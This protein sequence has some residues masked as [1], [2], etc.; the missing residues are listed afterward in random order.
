MKQPDPAPLPSVLR[1]GFM[2][3]LAVGSFALAFWLTTLSNVEPT[4]ANRR[5]FLP[6]VENRSRPSGAAPAGMV[7]VPGGEFSMGCDDPRPS[8]C[9]GP[10]AMADAR[11]V[12]RVYVDGF[13][14]DRTEVTN[15][16]FE[17]FAAAA[18]YKT[19]AEIA[20]TK[21]EFPTA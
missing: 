16:Q 5:A 7:W 21:E 6:T 2:A 11:P 3:L 9:G 12:H 17:K 20:P 10:D 18:G 1:W 4:S 19:I 15:E 8:L 14:M 13:W